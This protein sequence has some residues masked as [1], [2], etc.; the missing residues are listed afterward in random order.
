MIRAYQ[1]GHSH[2][3][4]QTKTAVIAPPLGLYWTNREV[5]APRQR[6][7]QFLLPNE[8]KGATPSE[9]RHDITIPDR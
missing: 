1:N 6:R 4:P 5:P 2:V 9:E 7:R 8:K 3:C